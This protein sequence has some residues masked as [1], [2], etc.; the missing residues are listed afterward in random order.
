MFNLGGGAKNGMSLLE[1]LRILEDLTGNKSEIK[2]ADW[3]SSDQK[4]YIS[5]TS[6]AK[7]KLGWSPKISPQEGVTR[8]VKW[9]EKTRR[10]FEDLRYP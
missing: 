10:Y 9:V 3:R 7:E 4:V 8:L 2:L 6:N 1:L 5:D